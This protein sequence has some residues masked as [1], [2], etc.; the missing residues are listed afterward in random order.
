[1]GNCRWLKTLVFYCTP[2]AED[3]D[4]KDPKHTEE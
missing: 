3:P 2:F 1:M 4:Q